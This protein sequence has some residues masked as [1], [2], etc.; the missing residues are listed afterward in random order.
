MHRAVAICVFTSVREETH[1][2]GH[3]KKGEQGPRAVE[4]RHK[5]GTEM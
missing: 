2:V 4:Q 5:H 3:G 1:R